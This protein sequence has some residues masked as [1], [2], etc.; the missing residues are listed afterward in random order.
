[1]KTSTSNTF[2]LLPILALAP[3]TLAQTNISPSDKFA[4][5]EN[6]GWLN[7]RDAGTPAGAQGVR[8]HADHLSGFIWGEN[9]GWINVGNGGGPY[10][11]T[12]NT[13]FGVNRNTANGFL[14]GYAWSE[15]AGW[16]N[17][18]G[19][20]LASPRNPA[21][22]DAAASRFRGYAWGENIGWINLDD[23]TH[24]VGLPC[25]ADVDD[26][27]GTGTPDGGVTID[28]LLYYL[29]IFNLGSIAADVDDGSGTGTQD[30]GV[31]IDDLLYFLT[32]FNAGC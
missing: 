19:G 7:F 18:N 11:N 23:A 20:N 32:R 28:D 22:F 6:C 30:G 9:L 5:S 24:F 8:L 3:A 13:N 31:T 12:N 10:A 14:T 4:W 1:M 17:F 29:N 26:G 25:V 21:R 15:N 27:T 16:I 2:M